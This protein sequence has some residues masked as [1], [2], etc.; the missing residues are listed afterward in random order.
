MSCLKCCSDK[1]VKNGRIPSGK[2]KFNCKRQDLRKS[3]DERRT[4][5]LLTE[6]IIK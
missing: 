5:K 3:H 6:I 2:L 4:F 1:I